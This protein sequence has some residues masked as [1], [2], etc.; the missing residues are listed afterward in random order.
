M[1]LGMLQ[2]CTHMGVSHYELMIKALR[3][4]Y[5]DD[6]KYVGVLVC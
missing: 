4:K 6:V 3:S 2:E 5:Y 1:C